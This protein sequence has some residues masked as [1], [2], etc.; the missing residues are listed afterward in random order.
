MYRR[1]Y[2]TDVKSGGWL[3]QLLKEV[4]SDVKSGETLNQMLIMLS[5]LINMR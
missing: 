2:K 3:N 4:K 5:K 1:F